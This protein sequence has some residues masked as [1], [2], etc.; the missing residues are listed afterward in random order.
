M[1]AIFIVLVSTMPYKLNTIEW[2]GLR[3]ILMDSLI[4]AQQNYQHVG[5]FCV[6]FHR[7]VHRLD[8]WGFTLNQEL[9]QYLWIE[10]LKNQTD[11]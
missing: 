5:T 4:N 6:I 1:Y 10:N 7:G 8:W 9:N 3:I 2:L 11:P